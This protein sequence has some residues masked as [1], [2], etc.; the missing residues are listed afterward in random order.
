M[1]IAYLTYWSV[2]EGLSQATSIPHLIILNEFKEV[3][4]IDYYTFEK[5]NDFSSVKIAPKVYHYS[6]KRDVGSNLFNK[7]NDYVRGWKLIHFNHKSVKYDLIIARS[8]FSGIFAFFLKLFY[9]IPFVVE[10]FEPHSEYQINIPNG[11]SKYGFRYLFLNTFER[12]EKKFSSVLLPVSFFYKEKLIQQGV[13]ENKI[14]V[15]PC[16]VDFNK[17][18]FSFETRQFVR[19]QLNIPDDNLVGIYAGKFGGLYYENEAFE[20]FRDLNK[21]LNFKFSIIILTPN[22]KN[23]L[24]NQL[25][26]FGFDEKNLNILFVQPDSVFDYLNA[27]DFAFNFHISSNVSNYFSPIKNAEYWS[28]GLPIIIPTG[29]GDDSDLV[30]KFNLG[31]VHD[32]SRKINKKQVDQLLFLIKDSRH[33]KFIFKTTLNYRSI[34][35]IQASYLE[36]FQKLQIR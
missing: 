17:F 9:G 8:S 29:I 22:D 33:K 12:L 4:R 18:N 1:K 19:Q 7:I 14:I 6:I 20:M 36:M 26:S 10:S 3:H 16:C 23:I 2:T 24:L 27:S 31:I 32:F 35:L 28:M 13:P 25:I 11:W 30:D 15:Q 5:Y 21:L 34:D